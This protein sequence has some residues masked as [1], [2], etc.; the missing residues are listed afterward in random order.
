MTQ[1]NPDSETM[2]T[3]NPDNDNNLMKP[4][5]SCCD[6]GPRYNLKL[7]MW[8]CLAITGIFFTSELTHF[9]GTK[10]HKM[11]PLILATPVIFWGAQPFFRWGLEGVFK[12][13]FNMFTLVSMGI[14]I[15]FCYSL[16][17]HFLPLMT[18]LKLNL[19]DPAG[20]YYFAAVITITTLVLIGQVIE[21]RMQ[22]RSG[23]AIEALMSLA[24]KNTTLIGDKRKKIPVSIEKVVPGDI[25]Y[26]DTGEHFPVDGAVIE[27]EGS[28]NE[29][30]VTG[31]AAL[32]PK[33]VGDLV[34]AGSENSSRPLTI[35]TLR[36]KGETFL[37]QIIKMVEHAQSS[38]LPIQRLVD[39]IS[40]YFVPGVLTI[41]LGTLGIWSLHGDPI[42]GL[43][44]AIAVMIIACPCALGLATPMS[45]MM[46]VGRGAQQGIL[47][48][49]AKALEITH[50]ANTL[51]VDKTGT[52]TW[53][54]PKIIDAVAL[55]NMSVKDSLKYVASLEASSQHPL[56]RAIVNRAIE[57]NIQL[58]TCDTITTHPGK[59]ISGKIGK[60]SVLAGNEKLMHDNGID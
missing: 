15:A 31:E 16:A 58:M 40:Q 22:E 26:I 51:V 1:T 8:V 11:L 35:K 25:L 50:K 36:T 6:S 24:P 42:L 10:V 4:V 30:F 44:C 27:G 59:G 7:R 49:H 12:G 2:S 56:A 3:A 28:V 47:I 29:A 23:S 60:I 38:E 46:G 32:V 19:Y 20:S 54:E 5:E 39:R 41:A 17:L 37:S 21:Q 55:N 9:F 18:L 34:L 52:L 48:K 14:T 45:I 53:G 13:K 57:E 33:K 43:L